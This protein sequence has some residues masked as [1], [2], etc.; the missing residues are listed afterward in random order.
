M[1]C[2]L[3]ITQ[4]QTSL[5]QVISYHLLWDQYD[6]CEIADDIVKSRM[7]H[8]FVK[9]NNDSDVITEMSNLMLCGCNVLFYFLFIKTIKFGESVYV[10]RQIFQNTC[11][12]IIFTNVGIFIAKL[13]S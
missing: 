4:Q 8:Y 11:I 5:P 13:I 3:I 10:R 7:P 2:I 1:G 9:T 12:T 6:T